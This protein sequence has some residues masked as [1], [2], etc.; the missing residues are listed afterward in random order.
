MSETEFHAHGVHEHALEHGSPSGKGGLAQY[1][2]I[3]TAILSTCGAIISYQGGETQTEAMLL[4]NEAVLKKA[5]ASDQWAFY[6][7]KSNK[8]HLMELASELEPTKASAYREKLEKY[9]KEKVEIKASAE[10]LDNAAKEAERQSENIL[11]PHYR[12][13]Q[14]MTFI[15]IAISLASITI[16]TRKKWLFAIA[17][18]AALAGVG[19]WGVAHLG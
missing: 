3:F 8:G 2:A 6:Q 9:E 16:L 17:G 11:G 4:K 13:S 10:A 5:E 7:S 1:V 18:L 15:Q 12:L 14:A 19:L